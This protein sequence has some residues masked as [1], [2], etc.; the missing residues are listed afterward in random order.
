LPLHHW[1]ARGYI[2]RMSEV[3]VNSVK[4]SQYVQKNLPTNL[5]T[6]QRLHAWVRYIATCSK[7][8]LNGQKKHIHTT[9][10]VLFQATI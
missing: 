8:A 1:C 9:V 3:S 10:K 4:H 5:G 6:I 7:G 2:A